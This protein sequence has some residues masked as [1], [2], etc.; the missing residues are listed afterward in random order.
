MKTRLTLAL[1][2]VVAAQAMLSCQNGAPVPLSSDTVVEAEWE[3]AEAAMRLFLE[4]MQKSVAESEPDGGKH[5]IFVSLLNQVEPSEEFLKQASSDR[6]VVKKKAE[7]KIDQH[8]AVVDVSSG[9]RGS[10][11]SVQSI[12]WIDKN[13]VEVSL[14]QYFNPLG[15]GEV[16]YRFV[17][18]DNT[19]VFKSKTLGAVS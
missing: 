7:A 6:I 4:D 13:E 16:I 3:V 2:M 14:W 8:G 10:R 9:E 1:I 5:Y 19:W 12:T 17:R 11:L 15:G 18:K